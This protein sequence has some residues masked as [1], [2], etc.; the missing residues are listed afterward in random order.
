MKKKKPNT[1]KR[2]TEKHQFEIHRFERYVCVCISVAYFI[3][4][5]RNTLGRV[6]G[7]RKT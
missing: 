7:R 3:I 1:G 6:P 2:V 4:I 5:P